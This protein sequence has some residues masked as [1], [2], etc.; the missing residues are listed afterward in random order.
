[1]NLNDSS[2]GRSG[3]AYPVARLKTESFEPAFDSQDDSS[4]KAGMAGAT[5]KGSETQ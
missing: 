1:M 4:A 5:R 2:K 3:C